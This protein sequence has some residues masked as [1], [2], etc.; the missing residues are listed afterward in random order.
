MEKKIFSNP[1][2]K[3]L[4]IKILEIINS[5]KHKVF[6]KNEVFSLLENTIK[7]LEGIKDIFAPNSVKDFCDI[8]QGIPS[9]KNEEL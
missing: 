5:I 9:E 6:S 1:E 8:C 3:Y 4:P 2:V 7:A